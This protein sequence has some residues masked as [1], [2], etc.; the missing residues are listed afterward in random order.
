MGAPRVH[1]SARLPPFIAGFTAPLRDSVVVLVFPCYLGVVVVVYMGV[2][3]CLAISEQEA[4][5]KRKTAHG[6]AVSCRKMS[7]LR[8]DIRY[9]GRSERTKKTMFETSAAWM[10]EKL[11]RY[12][13]ASSFAVVQ[14][15][16]QPMLSRS[17]SSSSRTAPRCRPSSTR[18]KILSP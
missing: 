12:D 3:V 5:K 10:G 7:R 6:M 1:C 8:N 11:R 15:P 18:G 14:R 2:R 16:A 17:Y 13:F 4:I 9:C